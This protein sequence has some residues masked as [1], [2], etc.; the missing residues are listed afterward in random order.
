M[1][2]KIIWLSGLF[3]FNLAV[4]AKAPTFEAYPAVSYN[5]KNHALKLTQ[6]S[7]IYRTLL[8]QLSQQKINFAGH[9]VVEVVGCGG[10]CSYAL[11]Y[12]AKTGQGFVL[13]DFFSDCYSEKNG[14]KQN[15]IYF[16]EN[17]RLMIAEGSR[18]G[19]PEQCE[20]VYYL[21]E[22]NQFKAI[23]TRP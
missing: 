23:N 19:N 11:A 13:P 17:S 2:V 9:Y 18:Y 10:G 15:D 3:L 7:R 4:F 8:A 1:I 6:Q 16:Q 21:V 20:T 12:N 14:F 22:N 5:S